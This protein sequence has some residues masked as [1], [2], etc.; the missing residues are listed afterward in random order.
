[1][2]NVKSASIWIKDS[3]AWYVNHWKYW[4]NYEDSTVLVDSSYRIVGYFDRGT[5]NID[6]I[7][8][9]VPFN[10]DFIIE[11]WVARETADI[12][13]YVPLEYKGLKTNTPEIQRA[14]GKINFLKSENSDSE[15]IEEAQ[16]ELE[17]ALINVKESVRD[18]N[19][20][21]F[22]NLKIA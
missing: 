16:R 22:K 9:S 20:N 10:Y 13:K 1:M 15:Q 8:T 12:V 6:V 11:N 3:I 21:Y 18:Y 2:A 5:P 14:K 4:H 19:I 7:M 17:E